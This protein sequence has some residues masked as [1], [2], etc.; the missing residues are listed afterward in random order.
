MVY[1]LKK[2]IDEEDKEVIEGSQGEGVEAPELGGQRGT[3][4]GAGGGDAA[5][6][7]QVKAEQAGVTDVSKYLDV[8]REQARTLA[9]KIGQ[10][11]TGDITKANEGYDSAQTQFGENVS[12]GTVN[13]NQDLFDKSKGFLTDPY[14]SAGTNPN[15]QPVAAPAIIPPAPTPGGGEPAENFAPDLGTLEPPPLEAPADQTPL[16]PG[17]N[18]DHLRQLGPAV[19]A[20]AEAAPSLADFLASADA[21]AFKSQYG[22]EYTGSQS[23]I[24]EEYYRNAQKQAD[25]ARRMADN[26]NTE[27]GRQELIKRASQLPS[28]RYTKGAAA[29]DQTLL[30]QDE[31]AFKIMQDAANP[32]GDLESKMQALEALAMEKVAEGKSISQAT[33][34]AYA[35]E[36]DIAREEGEIGDA[37]KVIRDE[38]KLKAAAE[39]ERLKGKAHE[40][41]ID[42]LFFFNDAQLAGLNKY[43]VA[44]QG[45]FDRLK[46]L[47]S[48]TGRANTFSPYEE[49]VGTYGD[50][51][52]SNRFFDED[53]YQSAVNTSRDSRLQIE[54]AEAKAEAEAKAAKDKAMATGIGSAVGAVAGGIAFGPVGAVVGA[55]LGGVI[56]GLFCFEGD[57]LVE[58]AD[59]TF[60]MIKEI[61][62]NDILAVG[63]RVTSIMN[64]ALDG[65]IYKYDTF[66]CSVYVTGTHAVCEN[67][68]WMRVSDSKNSERISR[69]EK[70]VNETFSL[71]CENHRIIIGG[72]V[73]S[74]YQEVNNN[75]LYTDAEC[76]DILNGKGTRDDKVREVFTGKGMLSIL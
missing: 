43:Q 49:Q 37:F 22:A 42:P 3:I 28:G 65:E 15:A 72:Q 59:G 21:D 29:L 8:N 13:L 34:E 17:G 16:V 46:A 5:E 33:K 48:L 66:Q 69:L 18:I 19:Q 9:G 36:F 2:P 1:E 55:V 27:E 47:E 6:P 58:M 44:G 54:A 63:G 23:I 12:G 76:L 68:E 25:E 56:G 31:E 7:L 74:D 70:E 10:G 51:V 61:K 67:G 64:N 57:T 75:H 14:A 32:A 26:I 11:I 30:S 45:D 4:A 73:F 41:G 71:S 52:D 53:K 50:V 60:K 35:E 24:N 40:E 39:K 20:P 38:A 62:I